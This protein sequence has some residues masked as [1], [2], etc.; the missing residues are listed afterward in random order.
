MALR[1]AKVGLRLRRFREEQ[2]LTQASLATALGISTSYVNQMESNQRPITGPV[3]LR[4]AEV[5]DVDVQ[6]FSA[7]ESD[8]L[9]AQLRDAL[10]DTAHAEQVS[11]HQTRELA[12]GMPELARYVVDLHRRYR[13]AVERNTAM[14]AEL[15]AGAAPTAY[16]EVRDLFYAKRNYVPE[17]DEAAER[18]AAGLDP[19]D[20]AAE[21]TRLLAE[22]HGTAVADL[23]AGEQAGAKR[24]FDPEGRVLRVSPLLSPGQR[25]F[26]LATH[27]ALVEHADLIDGLVAA[28]D[29]SGP[30]AR[31]LARIGLANYFA[32]ALILPYGVF[33]SAAEELRYDLDLLQRRFRVGF[34]TV[35]HRLSTLQR[36]GSRG[37]PFFFVRVDRAGNISKRQSATDFHFSRVGGSCPLWNVYE[38]FAHPGEVRTQL[39]QMPD[40]RSYL[41]VARTVTR[42]YGGFGTPAKTFAI[43][44]GCDLHHAHRLV[45]AD[46]LDLASPAALTPIGPGCKVCDRSGC[47][48]RAFPAIGRPLDVTDHR[49]GFTPYPSSA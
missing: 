3:L 40:G 13:H 2:G 38:A 46:G 31:A 47:P 19:A 36:P 8:R 12:E 16:E 35:A 45:Y 26:Q 9:D 28:A 14:S 44:L 32:G 22:R 24:R 1:T 48:Q 42:R 18:I 10:A 27:L 29:L 41:W 7:A 20:L 15:D 30:E 39:A 23:A 34:E 6:R 37:V 4:L 43:G 49:S 25:A 5:F 21:L 17:L 33:R 11:P